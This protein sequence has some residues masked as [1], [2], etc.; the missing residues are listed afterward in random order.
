MKL[1]KV[2]M[3]T[4]ISLVFFAAE[5]NE[6]GNSNPETQN[7]Q[8]MLCKYLCLYMCIHVYCAD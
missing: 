4:D 8:S 2:H 3:L 1:L 7:T 6:L 5:H